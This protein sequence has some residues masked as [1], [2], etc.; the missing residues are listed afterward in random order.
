MKVKA[1]AKI[2]LGL[3]VVKKNEDGFHELEMIMVPI[4]L[5]DLIYVDKIP[6]GIEIY[7]NSNTMPL[8]HRNIVYRVAQL[9]MDTYHLEGG[10]KIFIYKHIPT[11]AGMAGGSSDGAAVMRAI[12]KLYHLNISLDE[13]ANLGKSIGADIP[14]CIHQKLSF[15]SGIGERLEFFQTNL[16]PKI[17]LVKPKKGVS[18]KKSF[19]SL[20]LDHEFHPNCND[21][22]KCLMEDDYKHMCQCLGNTLE[23]VSIEIVPQIKEIKNKMLEMGFDC[24]LMSGSGSTVFGLTYDDQLLDDAF[25]YFKQKKLFVRKT[26]FI[27]V[28]E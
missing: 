7:S 24:A 21:I 8:D 26:E 11:Q 18:T 16:R 27:Q 10:V 4:A 19:Q 15:V 17:L 28:E 12:S 3:N 9:M 1:Y 20:Q 5:H 2:N 6:S 13:L 22:K 14:F 25:S 23:N